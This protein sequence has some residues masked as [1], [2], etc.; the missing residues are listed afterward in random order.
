MDQR[1][2]V[3]VHEDVEFAQLGDGLGTGQHGLER[4]GVLLGD[5]FPQVADLDALGTCRTPRQVFEVAA[6][7][8]PGH[9]RQADRRLSDQLRLRAHERDQPLAQVPLG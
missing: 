8:Q 6:E 3:V 5:P 1:E 2:A 7:R 4:E 9:G